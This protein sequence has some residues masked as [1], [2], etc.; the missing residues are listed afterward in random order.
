MGARCTGNLLWFWSMTLL[1]SQFAV[2][3]FFAP[4][5]RRFEVHNDTLHSNLRCY[6]YTTIYSVIF[7][8]SLRLWV[9]KLPSA[10]T[11]GGCRA[12]IP[13][14]S[15][16]LPARLP[17]RLLT[18]LPASLVTICSGGFCSCL[19]RGDFRYTTIHFKRLSHWFGSRLR[20]CDFM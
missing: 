16:R 2:L 13:K 11:V 20:R 8:T 10:N 15:G 1:Q 14:S 18:R 4:P 9:F 12:G 7:P 5:A 6:L 3:I 17:A 19:R